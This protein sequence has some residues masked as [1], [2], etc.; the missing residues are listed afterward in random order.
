MQ[1]L[2]LLPI[3]FG[4]TTIIGF[5]IAWSTRKAQVQITESNALQEMQKAYREFVSDQQRE[6]AELKLKFE[7]LEKE[8]LELKAE[9][10]RQRKKCSHCNNNEQ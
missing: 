4:G 7:A 2:E 1:L 8:H 10:V 5:Y 6:Y 9:M 3:I